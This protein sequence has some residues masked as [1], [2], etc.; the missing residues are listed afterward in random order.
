M[1][2]KLTLCDLSFMSVISFPKVFRASHQRPHTPSI[3]GDHSQKHFEAEIGLMVA[4]NSFEST[5]VD[6]LVGNGNRLFW[7]DIEKSLD[8]LVLI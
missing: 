5:Q 3:G 2:S 7:C 1:E 8:D 4:Y 6:G